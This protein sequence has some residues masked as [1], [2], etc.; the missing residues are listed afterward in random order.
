ML[1]NIPNVVKID[2]IKVAQ[3]TAKVVLTLS[4]EFDFFLEREVYSIRT[5][6][7]ITQATI[8]DPDIISS[9][10]ILM[11]F[12]SKKHCVKYPAHA[13]TMEI[14]PFIIGPLRFAG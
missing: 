9:F 14:T 13:N 1:H 3:I 2:R 5:I 7:V 6:T 11:I 8:A 4:F 10:R 12:E